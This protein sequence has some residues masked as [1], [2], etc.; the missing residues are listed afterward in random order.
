MDM[1]PKE[2]RSRGA[3]R[4]NKNAAKPKGERRVTMSVSVAP[5]T[6]DAILRAAHAENTSAGK[7]IDAMF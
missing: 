4:G 3:P 1:K 5:E 6:R 7:V 2:K